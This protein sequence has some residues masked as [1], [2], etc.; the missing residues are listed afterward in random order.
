M[1]IVK[2][3]GASL[4]ATLGELATRGDMAGARDDVRATGDRLARRLMVVGV[5]VII[6]IALEIVSIG[7]NLAWLPLGL[8][9]V[10]LC[11]GGCDG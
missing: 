7:V 10:R 2:E 8:V 5:G 9:G 4:E 11:E 1:A 6:L 3:R